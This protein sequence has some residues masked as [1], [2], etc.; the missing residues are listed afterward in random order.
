ML[1]GCKIRSMIRH[2]EFPDEI[3]EAITNAYEASFA[4][5][6]ET[7]LSITGHREL[8]DACRRCY[9]SLF[10][11]RAIS[12]REEQGLG[13]MEVAL[14]VGVQKMSC[15]TICSSSSP[16]DHCMGLQ[17]PRPPAW[18]GAGAASRTSKDSATETEAVEPS[19]TAPIIVWSGQEEPSWVRYA[20]SQPKR[21]RS[22]IV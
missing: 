22:R 11:D 16:H 7:F 8:L 3:A 4:G 14:S 18:Q 19:A 2:G 5:Q 15:S 13:H 6:Q 20:S 21:G 12:Y 17:W 1:L 10:T 9:A